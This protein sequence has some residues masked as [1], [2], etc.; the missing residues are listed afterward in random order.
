MT[1]PVTETAAL[2]TAA[3]ARPRRLRSGFVQSGDEIVLDYRTGALT[4]GFFMLLW[5][6]GWSVGC[7]FLLREVLNKPQLF[8][9]LFSIPFFAAW[10]FASVTVLRTF[11]GR[12]RFSLGPDG[13]R[14]ASRV[15]KTIAE[16]QAP[17]E[18]IVSIQSGLM[19]SAQDRTASP[20]IEVQT[21]GAPVRFGA[22]LRARERDWLCHVLG[23]HLAALRQ[24]VETAGAAGAPP[25]DNRWEFVT[26]FDGFA[27]EQRGCF[28]PASVAGLLFINAF[29]NGIVSVFIC[30]LFGWMPGQAPQGAA[31]W[32]LGVF[33]LPFEVVGLC[34]L[35]ALLR[36][37]LEPVRV[38]R[39]RISG[40]RIERTVRRLGLGR[41]WTYDVDRLERI[42]VVP[43]DEI[44]GNRQWSFPG[45]WGEWDTDDLRWELVFVGHDGGEVCTIPKLSRGEAEWMRGV[46]REERADRFR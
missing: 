31:R 28:E 1:D 44:D 3:P 39:W 40:S 18:E 17:L 9:V 19:A 12:E 33:L 30:V 45:T 27:F 42:D 10:I 34:M 43:P 25:H 6:S 2:E 29:W 8:M 35:I 20:V 26:D 38:T 46:I 11:F 24:G 15:F 5:L 36:A 22:A 4:A 7:V 32:G 23:E 16:R 14:Y 41:S 37:L 13:A 21:R